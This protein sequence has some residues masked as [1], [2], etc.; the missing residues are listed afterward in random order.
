MAVAALDGLL[1]Y[2][3][4]LGPPAGEDLDEELLRRF[5]AEGDEAAF[6]T[7]V[8]RHGP[9]VWSVSSRLLGHE[10]DAEDAF[11]ATFLILARKANAI[12]K[13]SAL[14]PWLYGVARRVA[15]KL[16]HAAA[17][18]GREC[19]A[20]QLPA[21]QND[22]MVWRDLR[23][24]L[25][26][27]VGRLPE[28]YRQPFVLCYLEGVTNDEA[29]R[30]LRCPKGTVVS[31]LSRARERL[32]GRLVRRGIELS[33][34]ALATILTAKAAPAAAPTA[35]VTET[36]RT[37]ISFGA[38]SASA[39]QAVTLASGVLQ[40]MFIT[41]VNIT[42]I[43]LAALCVVGSGV[44]LLGQA[45]TAPG[46]AA[47]PAPSKAAA[48]VPAVEDKK[49]AAAEPM[50]L[51]RG[52][53]LAQALDQ[54]VTF[55]GFDD[56]KT[57]LAEALDLFSKIYNVTFDVDEKA[58]AKENIADVLKT[59]FAANSPM[60]EIRAPLRFVIKKLIDRLPAESGATFVIR[61]DMIEVTTLGAVKAELGIPAERTLLPLVY[62]EF[63][64]KPL[65]ATLRALARAS[66]LS[67]VLDS[68]AAAASAEMNGGDA[69]K[70]T[71]EFHNVPV[72]TAVRV[73][74]DMA[75]MGM[76]QLDNVLYV[77]S[78][79]K[80]ARLRG[81]QAAAMPPKAAAAGPKK[82]AGK[83]DKSGM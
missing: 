67:I 56:P 39:A 71:A 6:T 57:T 58:F 73:L 82:P 27:E 22:D 78:Q 23:P 45:F 13:A 50:P 72:D 17:R 33:S 75:D 9:L 12:G 65:S 54:G 16:R 18:R 8:Q 66:G 30:R 15:L 42:V 29:A 34:A 21:P 43:V 77:T 7:L 51:T 31:R 44:G 68:Q 69:I 60:P 19:E 5:S 49:P 3:R 35:L 41:K 47:A 53:E 26:E 55:K 83:P 36:V 70:V 76:M 24:L 2:I 11:Q 32:R 61:K 62:E 20:G 74:A 28:K 4:R 48:K 59:E 80:A 37:G 81:E 46:T 79:A 63:E 1:R 52:M 40:S 14:G 10:Q 38:G 64:N 25:D